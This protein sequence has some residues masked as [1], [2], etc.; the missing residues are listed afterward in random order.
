MINVVHL[1]KTIDGEEV[2]HDINLKVKE[3]EIL[4]ILG[5]SGGG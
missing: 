1:Y 3:G 5:G 2:L 4:A